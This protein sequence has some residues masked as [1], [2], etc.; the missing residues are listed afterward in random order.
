MACKTIYDSD[1]L[2][3]RIN[4]PLDVYSNVVEFVNDG[5]SDMSLSLSL[6]QR[7]P[8]ETLPNGDKFLKF[9]TLSRIALSYF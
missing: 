4:S 2:E 6:N 1:L 5:S 8:E 9:V 7:L 3:P